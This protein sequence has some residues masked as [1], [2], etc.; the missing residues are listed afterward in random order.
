[1]LR[2]VSRIGGSVLQVMRIPGSFAKVERRM[3]PCTEESDFSH[4]FS[5]LSTLNSG[6]EQ[7]QRSSVPRDDSPKKGYGTI[8]ERLKL[9]KMPQ[10][11]P[12]VLIGT[13]AWGRSGGQ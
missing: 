13:L 6:Q 8:I 1:M 3:D 4:C 2:T 7:S 5:I 11:S 9:T 12:T 10:S